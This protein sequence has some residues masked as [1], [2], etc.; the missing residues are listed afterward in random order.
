MSKNNVHILIKILYFFLSLEHLEAIVGL[1]IGL[2]SILLRSEARG[3]RERRGNDR[4]V[5][6]SE[7]TTF[8]DYVRRLIWARFVAPQNSYN[9]NIK[10]H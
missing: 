6:Q 3:N 7:H 4:W 9:S 5:E 1:L 8:I 10:D 2:I